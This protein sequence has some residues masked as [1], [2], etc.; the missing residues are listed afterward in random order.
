MPKCRVCKQSTTQRF[1]LTY[2]CG[3]EHAIEF[4]MLQKAKKDAKQRQAIKRETR[5]RRQQI[6]SLEAL[7]AKIQKDVNKYVMT[8]ARADG[9][10]CISC[11]SPEISDAGHF[12][13]AGSKYRTSRLRFDL[14]ILE[15]QCMKCNRF[16]GGGNG[17]AYEDGLL[18]R[19]G[20]G[21]L[22]EIE[23]LKRQADS[24]ELAPLTKEE[25]IELGKTY[26]A[27]TRAIE[28]SA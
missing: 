22:I 21:R 11:N 19:Y 7:C 6:M 13:H 15:P 10:Y 18:L 3:L 14:R 8:K 9:R 2:A 28:R 20:V 4:A 12:I 17:R 25:V 26:R 24:G 1:G 16:E 23:E 5:E 27:M